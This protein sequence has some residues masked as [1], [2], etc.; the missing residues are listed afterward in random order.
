MTWEKIEVRYK[1]RFTLPFSEDAKRAL[2]R[3]NALST[4]AIFSHNGEEVFRVDGV[5]E[6][7]WWTFPLEGKIK[8]GVPYSMEVEA[9]T[10]EQTEVSEFFAGDEWPALDDDLTN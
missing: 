1:H 5:K 7:A 2:A 9:V 6:G 8:A 4:T 3:V 10:S